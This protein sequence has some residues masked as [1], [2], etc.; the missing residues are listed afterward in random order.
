MHG[1]RYLLLLLLLIRV[2]TAFARLT[3]TERSRALR[4][5]VERDLKR[6]SEARA[7][8]RIAG[9]NGTASVR[10]A[11][12]ASR[13][14]LLKTVQQLAPRAKPAGEAFAAAAAA[15]EA[16]QQAA[17]S[18]LPLIR[19]EVHDDEA[20]RRELA[21]RLEDAQ[22]RHARLLQ[23]LRRGEFA[24]LAGTMKQLRDAW[25]D[26]AW[27]DGRKDQLAG[28]ALVMPAGVDFD[29]AVTA[30]LKACSKVMENEGLRIGLEAAHRQ[31]R[32]AKPEMQTFAEML[33]T[34][35]CLVGL[36][37][38]LLAERLSEAAYGHS[39]EMINL[40]YFAHESPVAKNKSPWDRARNAKFEGSAAGENIFAGSEAPAEAYGGW[41]SSDGHRFIMFADGVNALGV[42]RYARDWT[43]MTG[44][45]AVFPL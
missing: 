4:G 5:L 28:D 12:E 24:E 3:E 14:S 17:A 29:P 18:A 39:E 42:G 20:K 6:R 35:R 22:N 7:L 2:D 31:Y 25:N 15:L 16:W 21:R 19:T 26:L 37:P 27:L 1:V 44:N 8:V 30:L 13:A 33:N 41:W 32:W 36:R 11:L 10:L 38:L 40:N 9:T 45:F 43:M 23:V 34:Q